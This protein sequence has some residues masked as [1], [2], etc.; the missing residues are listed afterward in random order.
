MYAKLDKFD[1]FSKTFSKL[2]C[3]YQDKLVK[4]AHQLLKAHQ[5]AKADMKGQ[6]KQEDIEVYPV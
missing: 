3:E 1:V 5:R 2:D 6:T 4:A